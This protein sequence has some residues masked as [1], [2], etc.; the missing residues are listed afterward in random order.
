MTISDHRALKKLSLAFRDTA[1]RALRS[2][3]DDASV[4]L[5]RLL[6]FV[7]QTPLLAEEVQRAPVP[8]VDAGTTWQQAQNAGNRLALPED[9]LEELGVLHATIEFLAGGEEDFWKVCF[10]YASVRGYG[11]CVSEVLNDVVGK[12]VNHLNRVIELALLDSADPAYGPSRG[13]SIRVEGGNNQLNLAQDQGRV[14]ATQHIGADV[15][16]LVAAA[17]ELAAIA[18]RA[19]IPDH[20]RSDVRDVA[21]VVAE[22]AARPAPSRFTLRKAKEH[23]E[24]IA[25]TVGA[26]STL[27][28]KAQTLA[29]LLGPALDRLTQ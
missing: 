6:T 3:S 16:A 2:N 12:Y 11:E 9:P 14:E 23:L 10:N 20:V 7:R 28:E 4:N 13:V 8:S 27:G 25:A 18:D 17:R 1:S 21:T 29:G 5:R 26:A 15:A 22:E 24:L 19:D